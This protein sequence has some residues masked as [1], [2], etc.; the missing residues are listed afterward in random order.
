MVAEAG[1]EE[2]EALRF[3][4]RLA[5]G[6]VDDEMREIGLAGH[7]AERG[8][9]GRGEADEIQLA[10][11]RIGHIVEDGDLGR[12][13]KVA[14]LAEMFGREARMAG[15]THGFRSEEH[16]SEL[17]SLMRISYAVFCLKKKNKKTL[18][19]ELHNIIEEI[20]QTNTT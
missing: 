18:K 17:Q 3:D 7:R 5:G 11:A 16:T 2:L 20:T 6:I 8:E 4:D 1:Q 12:G 19:L 14:R 15:I 10:R 13:R 9:F